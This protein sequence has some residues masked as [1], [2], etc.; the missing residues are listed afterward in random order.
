MQNPAIITRSV[1]QAC[2][3]SAQRQALNLRRQQTK[4][5]A[6][7]TLC[8]KLN[9]RDR[10][11]ACCQV[12]PR[13]P[14]PPRLIRP[15][16]I[17]APARSAASFLFFALCPLFVSFVHSCNPTPANAM[18]HSSEPVGL[19]SAPAPGRGHGRGNLGSA[20]LLCA[21]LALALLGA[22]STASGAERKQSGRSASTAAK[23]AAVAANPQAKPKGSVKIKHQRSPSEESTA[24]RDRRLYRECRGRPNAGACLGYAHGRP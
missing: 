2:Q 17:A 19:V 6:H 11:R 5:Q 8:V 20:A 24:E 10:D 9:H 16:H 15:S 12:V 18:H 14:L 23:T 3:R 4:K 22:G 13:P 21:C 1:F 7:V